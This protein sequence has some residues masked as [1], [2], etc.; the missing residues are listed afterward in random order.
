MVVLFSVVVVEVVVFEHG[1]GSL[2]VDDVLPQF[3][4]LTTT[5]TLNKNVNEIPFDFGI[6]LNV[7]ILPS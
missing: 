1:G 4:T 5:I 3:G 7:D 2:V 6:T